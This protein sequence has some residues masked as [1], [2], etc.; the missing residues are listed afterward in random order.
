MILRR[1]NVDFKSAMVYGTSPSA[2]YAHCDIILYAL[3]V[4]KHKQ[5]CTPS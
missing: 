3:T 4:A 2:I 5:R 1:E